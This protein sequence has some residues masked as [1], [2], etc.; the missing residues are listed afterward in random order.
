LSGWTEARNVDI[1]TTGSLSHISDSEKESVI[2]HSV[3]MVFCQKKMGELC[4]K[5][6][7]NQDS[8]K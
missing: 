7:Y 1:P 6:K 3:G 8:G 4:V 2:L 5:E